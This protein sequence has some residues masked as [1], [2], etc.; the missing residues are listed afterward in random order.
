MM[1]WILR[2]QAF[3]FEVKYRP[4]ETNKVADALSRYTQFAQRYHLKG[5]IEPLYAIETKEKAREKIRCELC[6]KHIGSSAP[7]EMEA[8]QMFTHLKRRKHAHAMRCEKTRK[9]KEQEKYLPA[10]IANTIIT[11]DRKRSAAYFQHKGKAKI[12]SGAKCSRH[13]TAHTM[14]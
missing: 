9:Q 12:T 7:K 2:L 13:N 1:R 4:G 6:M 5:E 11:Q 10:K 14:Q 8:S 3:D